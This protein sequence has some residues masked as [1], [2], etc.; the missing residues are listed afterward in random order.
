MVAFKIL[1]PVIPS[2]QPLPFYLFTNTLACVLVMLGGLKASA[3]IDA[4]QS[5]L[6]LV[7]SFILIPFGLLRIGGLPGLHAR[8]PAAMFSLF[9]SAQTS[10]YA[11]YSIAAF[12]LLTF[13]GQNSAW[14]NMGICGSARDEMA[15]RFGMVS[16]GFAKR[17]ITM[18]WCACGLLAVA[19]YGP[20]LADPDTAWGSLTRTL[21]PVGLVGVMLVGMLGGKLASLGAG[22]VVLCA[23]VVKNLYEPLFPGRSNAHYMIV[24]RV[25]VPLMFA[26]GILVGL[27]LTS[28]IEIF[29]T[30]V[31]LTVV[32]GAPILLIFLWRRLTETAVRVQVVA[33]FL[34]IGIV[35]LAVSAFPAGRHS[36]YFE[37]GRFNLELYTLHR[38]GAGVPRW[39]PPEKLAA[40]YLVDSALPFLLL[41]GVSLLTRPTDPKRVADFYAR[42]K[43]PVGPSPEAEA[44]AL[45]ESRRN[46]ARFDHTKVFPGSN[47]EFTKWDRTDAVGFFACCLMVAFIIVVMKGLLALV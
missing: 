2:L 38:L 29:K 41:F 3:A 23:I 13:I 28:A 14:G 24:A 43:T 10:E 9:G 37:N 40:R 21:L 5:V 26:S 19:I 46:P 8:V 32:W 22:T 6:T 17:F 27:Y 1:H 42:M 36:A 35:P 45:A 34:F 15:A 7:I 30:I 33:C 39:S 11:W 44:L 31:A 47:W 12:L 16:G 4:I 25:S 20:H 18:A